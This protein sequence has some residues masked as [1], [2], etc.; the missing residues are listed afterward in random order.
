MSLTMFLLL[1]AL[2]HLFESGLHVLIHT[3]ECRLALPLKAFDLLVTFGDFQLHSNA[4]ALLT[5]HFVP[6]TNLLL[7]LSVHNS[8]E[9]VL[10]GP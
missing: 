2:F 1:L 8:F 7:V 6:G 9:R 3:V 5:F 10:L 4:I